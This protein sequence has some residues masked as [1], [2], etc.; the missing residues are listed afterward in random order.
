MLRL[1]AMLPALPVMARVLYNTDQ[2]LV[3]WRRTHVVAF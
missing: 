1:Q 3:K 2:D